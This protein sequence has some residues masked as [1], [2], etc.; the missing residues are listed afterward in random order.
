M[1]AKSKSSLHIFQPDEDDD[2]KV[3]MTKIA[4]GP[5]GVARPGTVLDVKE[6]LGKQLVNGAFAREY[7]AQRD[8]KA[9]RGWTKATDEN[10]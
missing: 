2:M 4:A 9:N 5:Q 7:D 10:R 3:T 8:A 6:D 1:A